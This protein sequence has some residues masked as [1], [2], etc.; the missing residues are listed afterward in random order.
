MEG[1]T[2]SKK[3]FPQTPGYKDSPNVVR[4]FDNYGKN[5]PK[6]FQDKYRDKLI[7]DPNKLKLSGDGIFFT[8]QGEG[9]STGQPAVFMRLH[10]CNLACTYCDAYYTWQREVEEFWKESKDYDIPEIARLLEEAWTCE[11]KT[12]KR[13][14]LTGGE[15]T[16][17]K[18]QITKLLPLLPDWKV[19]IE[20]N[21]TIMPT[22]EMLKRLQFNC[23]PKLRNSGNPD[24]QRI[25][26]NV[27]KALNEVHT[28]F[29]F[30]VINNEDLDEIENDF[31]KPFNLDINKVGIMPQGVSQEEINENMA[32]VVD[33]C[34]Q[35]GYRMFS[36]LHISIFGGAKRRV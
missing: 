22:P 7:I 17:Q 12:K 34:K 4:A 10:I 24:S 35:K 15:P 26:P 36:R 16:L 21:G 11:N 19:E 33:K 9:I 18:N 27:L 13:L 3:K 20:T 32:R 31:I 1:L 5:V 25:R 29:K 6:E 23:S 30:V 8:I 14:V 28:T 2:M